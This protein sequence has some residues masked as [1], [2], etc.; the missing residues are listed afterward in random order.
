MNIENRLIIELFARLITVKFYLRSLIFDTI[1]DSRHFQLLEDEAVH[2]E[3]DV[4]FKH[5]QVRCPEGKH[6]EHRIQ[7]DDL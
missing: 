5:R 1:V 6:Q 3:F 4:Q 2:E 7:K